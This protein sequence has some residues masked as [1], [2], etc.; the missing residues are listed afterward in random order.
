ME[1]LFEFTSFLTLAHDLKS[2]DVAALLNTGM[3]YRDLTILLVTALFAMVGADQLLVM[4]GK[5]GTP[6]TS[7]SD[8]T[9][10]IEEKPFRQLFK[11]QLLPGFDNHH[12]KLEGAEQIGHLRFF[13]YNVL[14]IAAWLI[15][16]VAVG[17]VLRS[18][19]V[20]LF[21]HFGP[22]EV[23]FIAAVMG[24]YLIFMAAAIF[25]NKFQV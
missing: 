9:A 23:E 5:L 3:E 22:L 17:S 1:L 15:L 16:L 19:W 14:A 24:A 18:L 8:S 21:G 20:G 10:P 4:S 12:S 11:Y 13:F 6:K 2:A 25:K 7:S